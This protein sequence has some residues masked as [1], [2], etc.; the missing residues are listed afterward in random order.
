MERLEENGDCY[1]AAGNYV[2]NESLFQGRLSVTLVHGL[3]TLQRPPWEKFGHAWVEYEKDSQ[4][5]VLDLSN[6]REIEVSALVY[7][8]I[9]NID[10]AECHRYSF[11]DMR[12]WIRD[13]GHWGPWRMQTRHPRLQEPT[14]KT[15]K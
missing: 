15:F 1:E 11:E 6:G 4:V 8:T 13:T 14:K 10:P 12:W 9:G 2:V 3:P 7:Y 5:V